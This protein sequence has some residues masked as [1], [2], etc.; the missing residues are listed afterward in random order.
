M[1]FIPGNGAR[2]TRALSAER[3]KNSQSGC[4]I[5]EQI[6]DVI[7]L[8]QTVLQAHVCNMCCNLDTRILVEIIII[9]GQGMRKRIKKKRKW[10]QTPQHTISNIQ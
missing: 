9:K 7:S 2:P 10:P 1:P 3:D 4:R 5:R 6:R 8:A